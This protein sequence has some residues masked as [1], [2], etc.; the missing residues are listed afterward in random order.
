[1]TVHARRARRASGPVLV[2]LASLLSASVLAGMPG[3]AGAQEP[4]DG[5]APPGVG[6]HTWTVEAITFDVMTGPDGDIPVTID[7]DL[8]RP[9][10]ASAADPMPAIVHQHGYGGAKDNAESVTNAAYLAG[11]GYVVVTITTQGFGAS[12]G[13]IALDRIDYDGA[14]VI[15]IVDWLAG[16][17]F[18]A[19]DAPGDPK[20]GLMGGSY[21][22]GH[23]GLVA[24]TDPRVDAI[25]PGRTWHTLQYSLVPNNWADPAAPW[26]LDHAD[27]GVF[28]QEWTSLFFALGAAQPAQGNGGCDPIT[29][30]LTYP[31]AAPCSGYIPGVCQVY[32]QL[33]AAGTADDA[34][35]ALVAG[36]AVA[37]RIDE[38]DTPTIISQ[39]LPD[40]LFTPN[41]TVPALRSLQ[42]RG[43]PVAVIWHSSGHGGYA[44][45][46]GDGEPYGGTFDD[47]PES[48][49]VYARTYFAR[50]HLN[51]FERHDA[52]MDVKRPGWAARMLRLRPGR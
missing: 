27:Q 6:P 7:A 28:K 12:T 47:S 34:G 45:A 50:R 1:M 15:A 40:T 18:V 51:W 41:E 31:T 49:K 8:W 25:A 44:P 13:C 11:H 20:V 48:Q 38:L 3:P 43:V 46:P 24:V 42:E 14:N 39:G 22:G 4:G 21:G 33:V 35:R 26:D 5:Q 2:L 52:P 30:Q 19:L 17:D 29:R 10:D 23:Q 16:Q 32:A 9:D 36:S 37:T